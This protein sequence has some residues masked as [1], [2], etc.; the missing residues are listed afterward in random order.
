MVGL[1][2]VQAQYVA[3]YGPGDYVPNVFV[4]YWSM[5]VMAYLGSLMLLI[6]AVG[7]AGSGDAARRARAWFLRV[8]IWAV[9]VPFVVNTAGWMLTENGRQPW[10]VQ[11]LHADRRTAC[12]RRSASARV[13][14]QLGVFLVLYVV[15][16]VVDW[17]LMWRYARMRASRRRARR[18]R[19]TPRTRA[20][21]PTY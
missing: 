19:A 13:I 21:E 15:L 8:A 1:N 5:R 12:R 2:D 4:Q 20:L 7:A 3:Q 10:I 14:D 6:G 18:A 16:G 9:P 17:T 11:G